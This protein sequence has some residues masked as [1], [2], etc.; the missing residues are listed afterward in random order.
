[1]N[2]AVSQAIAELEDYLRRYPSGHFSELA[3][4]RLDRLLAERGEKKVQVVSD[5][6]NPF[7]KGTIAANLNYRVG[8]FYHYRRLDLLTQIESR[9]LRQRITT[10]TDS[11]VI[12]N[13][14]RF[15]TDLL[16]NGIRF[17]NGVIFGP[18]QMFA[19][20]YSVGKK[21]TTRFPM[22]DRQG[23]EDTVELDFKVIGRET[24]TVPAGTFD[25]FRVEGHGWALDRGLSRSD[26]YWVAPDKVPRFVALESLWRGKGKQKIKRSDRDELVAY[27]PA[28]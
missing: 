25:C 5:A 6:A 2:D 16:G 19:T 13:N 9:Q 20:E 1:M 14:G 15:A 11:E 23:R 17:P 4:L 27:T 24:I 28:A 8:D 21:W 22:T 3:Q 7:S 12:Y 26:T 10:I 18:N